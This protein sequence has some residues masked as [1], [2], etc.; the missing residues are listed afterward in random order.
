MQSMAICPH[1]RMLL[2]PVG[3]ESSP[4]ACGVCG[5]QFIKSTSPPESIP[6][7][8][9]VL[10]GP[11]GQYLC[12]DCLAPMDRFEEAP[13]EKF[14]CAACGGIWIEPDKSE[15]PP[16]P[17]TGV[18]DVIAA[19]PE[20]AE[21]SYVK[22]LLYGISLPERVL[23]TAVGVT[24]GTAREAAKL[25]VPVS[26]QSSKSYEVAIKNSLDFLT[27]TVG[28]FQPETSEAAEAGETLAKKAV[29]NFLDIA[30]MATL[31]ISPMWVMAAVSDIAYGSSVYVKELAQELEKQGV[32]DEASTIHNVDDFLNAIQNASGRVASSIDKP[33]LS[34]E[35][36][37]AFVN[38]TRESVASANIRN[39][40]P[41]KEVRQ[42][43]D[44]LSQVARK[45]NMSL[46]EAATAVAMH[47]A[48]QTSAIAVNAKTG[49][50]VAGGLL[51]RNVL[52]HYQDSL[53]SIRQQGVLNV[54][55]TTYEP[56]AGFIWNNFSGKRASWTETLID[57]GKGMNWLGWNKPS[58]TKGT[59][60]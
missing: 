43:W 41:E 28:G 25:L 37:R 4:L 38:E 3:D 22:S 13:Q 36:F 50:Q 31:H 16:S 15:T 58:D 44:S 1:C 35:E 60:S 14:L 6:E 23:R 30:G 53:T 27:E 18:S 46:F 5:G 24:A 2:K 57:A 7:P 19:S 55:R 45:E 59:S 11:T 33:P 10:D 47:T 49:F 40:L 56:Y 20:T 34:V 17:F 26:F 9:T 12:P 54:L 32:I 29:G 8:V 52:Q 48:Q 42:Y 51:Q 21:A 39:V